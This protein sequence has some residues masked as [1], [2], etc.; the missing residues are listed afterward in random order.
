M[1]RRKDRERFLELKRLDPDYSGFRG[2][3]Q[4]PTR[5]GALPLQMVTCSRCGRMRNVAVG[6]AVEQGDDYVCLS[7]LEKEGDDAQPEEVVS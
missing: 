3:D 1:S 5:T 4:D 7:C 6:I 2:N